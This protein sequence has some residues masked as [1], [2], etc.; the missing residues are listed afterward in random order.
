M[1]KIQMKTIYNQYLEIRGR[2]LLNFGSFNLYSLLKL[3][4]VHLRSHNFIILIQGGGGG[5]SMDPSHYL[6]TYKAY[7]LIINCY[8]NCGIWISK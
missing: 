8:P 4:Q 2:L 6:P 7:Q 5:L 3:L 1:K